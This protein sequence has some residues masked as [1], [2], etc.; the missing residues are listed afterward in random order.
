MSLPAITTPTGFYRRS[1]RQHKW[2]F[3]HVLRLAEDYAAQ[4]SLTN[5][6]HHQELHGLRESSDTAKASGALIPTS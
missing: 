3:A 1:V 6:T 2:A 5:C 4:A